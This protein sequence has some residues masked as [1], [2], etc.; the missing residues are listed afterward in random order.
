VSRLV[1]VVLVGCA[2]DPDPCAGRR[3]LATSP[4][5]LALTRA[6]HPA[7]WGRA[8]CL[9]CHPV[10]TVHQADCIDGVDVTAIDPTQDCADC[11]GDNGALDGE[12]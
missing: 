4:A 10:W 8:E 3:D 5:G 1:L 2:V 11:H 6:E 9:Q 12:T 7:G